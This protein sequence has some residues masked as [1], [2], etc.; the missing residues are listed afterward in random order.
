MI[1][2]DDLLFVE[3]VNSVCR[4]SGDSGVIA[5]TCFYRKGHRTLV[6]LYS[7]PEASHITH[8]HHLFRTTALA[9][10][11][12]V[13]EWNCKMRPGDYP[14]TKLKQFAKE[15]ASGRHPCT[16]IYVSSSISAVILMEEFAKLGIRVPEDISLISVGDNVEAERLGLTVLAP[17]SRQTAKETMKMAAALLY[18]R[19]NGGK[20]L[21]KE[22]TPLL[23]ERNSVKTITNE[24]HL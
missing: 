15:F 22:C 6:S 10:G 16:G 5:A 9:M 23:I 21:Q 12:S 4:N 17:I 14:D 2:L 24:E 18:S 20:F 13:E 7:E 1:V 11:C 8:G 19:S 3:G